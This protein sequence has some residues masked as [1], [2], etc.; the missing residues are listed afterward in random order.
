FMQEKPE[1]ELI[2]KDILA[3]DLI[4]LGTPVWAGKWA[5]VFNT[6]FDRWDF[7]GKKIA[8]FYCHAGAPGSI[9]KRFRRKL[10][11][12]S[13]LGFCDFVD[14]LW[15]KNSE[16]QKQKARKWARDMITLASQDKR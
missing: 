9:E 6:L 12:A 13:L 2:E 1:L 4:F 14:P 7:G 8:C 5:P 3:Y 16:E 11:T 10:N 15:S